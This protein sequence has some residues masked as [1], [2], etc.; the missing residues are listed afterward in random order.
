MR[1]CVFVSVRASARPCAC[2]A[3]LDACAYGA[4]ACVLHVNE[5]DTPAS[6][7]LNCNMP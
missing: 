3:C 6:Q 7:G 4:R 1:V 5:G 2:G